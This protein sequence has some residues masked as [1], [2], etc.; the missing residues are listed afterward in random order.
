MG[1]VCKEKEVVQTA[2][3]WRGDLLHKW[4]NRRMN[5]DG[6][7]DGNV[8]TCRVYWVVGEA[9]GTHFFITPSS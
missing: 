6:G 9:F 1:S 3:P 7:S 5:A 4:R 2:G 8:A